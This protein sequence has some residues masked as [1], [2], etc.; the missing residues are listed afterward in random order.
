MSSKDV[1]VESPDLRAALQREIRR[2]DLYQ[3]DRLQPPVDQEGQHSPLVAVLCLWKDD[4][5]IEAVLASIYPYAKK[6]ICL[7]NRHPWA[8]IATYDPETERLVKQF[9]DLDGKILVVTG[10]WDEDGYGGQLRQRTEGFNFCQQGD[11]LWLVDGDEVYAPET[12]EAILSWCR[13]TKADTGRVPCHSFW[14]DCETIGWSEHMARL[15]RWKPGSRFIKP[16]TVETQGCEPVLPCQPFFHVGYV[17]SDARITEKMR[18]YEERSRRGDFYAN[19]SADYWLKEV[20]T[21]H[22]KYPR[23]AMVHP[24][25]DVYPSR[26]ERYTGSFP[27]PLWNHPYTWVKDLVSVVTVT[28]NS[29]RVIDALMESWRQH[30]PGVPC[31][32]IIIDSHSEVAHWEAVLRY[33]GQRIGDT[34]ISV[35]RL[36]VNT[37]FTAAS[38][39]GIQRARGEH[40]LL[41]NPD[42]LIREPGWLTQFIRDMQRVP[43][44][45][46]AGCKQLYS[47]G[48]IQ[49]AGGVYQDGKPIHR[50]CDVYGRKGERDLG[51]FMQVEQVPWV[52][53]SCMLI[54]KSVTIALGLLDQIT[55]PHYGSDRVYCEEARRHGFAVVYSPVAVT[56]LHGRSSVIVEC[57]ECHLRT[58]EMGMIGEECPKCEL[59][60]MRE[61]L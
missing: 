49:H 58:Y 2:A 18:I 16:N 46:I 37:G 3:L 1:G 23:V 45:A 59:A 50:G 12:C 33:G 14:Q 48:T 44:G 60:K 32:W 36:P 9:P 11:W 26:V 39:A 29:G 31:E 57:P 55:Y 19:F 4:D 41:L 21:Q 42:V 40:V 15:F 25:P 22:R 38:N 35:W 30:A 47:D 27:K 54:H 5:W 10:D 34:P 28:Y 20:W 61:V 8:G 56:H 24:I 53:G 6:I 52:T 13:S 51:Q 7:L 17:R 43:G